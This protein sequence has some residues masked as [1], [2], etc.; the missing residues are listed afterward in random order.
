MTEN[1]AILFKTNTIT[2]TTKQQILSKTSTIKNSVVSSSTPLP[3]M[4]T[5][6]S[7]NT[8]SCYLVIL[9]I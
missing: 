2:N 7:I 5:E 9:I 3:S 6:K 8:D 1:D 4:T